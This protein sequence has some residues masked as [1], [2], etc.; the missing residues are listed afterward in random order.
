M[1]DD[2][3]TPSAAPDEVRASDAPRTA[4]PSCARWSSP[5]PTT[6]PMWR[7]SGRPSG[8]ARASATPNSR[9]WPCLT[10]RCRCPPKRYL[11]LIG[12]E[13]DTA[14]GHQV[15]DQDRWPRAATCSRSST[16]T[17]TRSG[18]AR[19]NAAIRVPIDTT[20]FG[21]DGD[22]ASPAGR[23]SCCSR[24]TAST[25][26]PPGSG[27]TSTQGPE[28]D[29]L[30]DAIVGVEVP[31]AEPEAMNALWHDLLGLGAPAAADT[32]DLG[33]SL[34]DSSRAV[35]RPTGRWCCAASEDGGERAAD[36]A[37]SG[38][39]LPSASDPGLRSRLR[40]RPASVSD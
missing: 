14:V 11:E 20:A 16:R 3:Q 8:S 29:A 17:R 36:P 30:V 19:W 15:A 33:G 25:M 2:V 28:P 23:R 38:H 10:P 39:H 35:H 21:H 24:S 13:N 1:A 37:L 4:G 26:T 9:I 32:I 40:L 7:R 27:T 12:P 34:C 5:P 6:P 22:P 18:R 31:V